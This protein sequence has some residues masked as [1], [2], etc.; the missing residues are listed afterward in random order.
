[1]NKYPLVASGKTTAHDVFYSNDA[2]Q[3]VL[4]ERPLD[5]EARLR[6]TANLRPADLRVRRARDESG[7]RSRHA[8]SAGRTSAKSCRT[9]G[10][11][12]G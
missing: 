12:P 3:I 6:D 7:R 5:S 8:R 4:V 10:N 2:G 1:M 11:E 9:Q